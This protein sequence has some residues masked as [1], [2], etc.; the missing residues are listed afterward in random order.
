MAREVSVHDEKCFRIDW[1][2]TLHG[3]HFETYTAKLCVG[4]RGISHP[5]LLDYLD[6]HIDCGFEHF[7]DEYFEGTDFV[8]EIL[9]TI[10]RFFCREKLPVLRK[11]LRILIAYSFT[12]HVI[13][14]EGL[15]ENVCHL[16]KVEDQ[17]SKCCGKT[18]GPVLVNLQLKCALG[19]MWRELQ[20]DV[21]EELSSL[22][23]SVYSGD[24]LRHWPTIFMLVTILLAVWEL[25][26]FDCNYHVLD[27]R[28]VNK[29]TG[30]MEGTPVG[31]IV[32]L[33]SA[34]SQKLPAFVDRDTQ[35]HH[36]P[37]N[38]K[39]S[40]CD[41]MNEFHK[42]VIKY[43]ELEARLVLIRPRLIKLVESYLGSRRNCKF[44]RC[45]FD[46][47]S[48]KFLSRLVIREK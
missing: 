32:G 37:L 39:E 43:G 42:H 34:L 19:D 1:V 31:V 10:Y 16:G 47:L 9:K 21:L 48:N 24:R 6:R 4:I 18:I 35:T 11:A 38:S 44:D 25:I 2:E 27:Q 36:H 8:T 15:P 33:F 7:V 22:Y 13:M 14:V 45:N 28:A 23:S 41:V 46:S 12:L 20:K 29:F 30:E 17:Q 3:L 26:Q 40:V 5:M